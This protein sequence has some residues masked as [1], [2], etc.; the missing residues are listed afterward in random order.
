[1]AVQ[2][3]EQDIGIQCG[4]FGSVKRLA[5]FQR[6]SKLRIDLAGSDKVM[7]MRVDSGLYAQ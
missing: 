3:L 2:P 1:M 4:L 6:K 5:G 7:C